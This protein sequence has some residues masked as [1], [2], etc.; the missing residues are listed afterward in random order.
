[1]MFTVQSGS[2]AFGPAV[3]PSGKALLF[4]TGKLIPAAAPL[5]FERDG[6]RSRRSL[7]G[8]ATE[9]Q[10]LFRLARRQREPSASL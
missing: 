9:K 8:R 1:M 7:L 5:V 3:A 4:R 2:F 6:R 10:E